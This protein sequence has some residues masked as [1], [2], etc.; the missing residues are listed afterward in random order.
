MQQAGVQYA[1]PAGAVEVQPG[2]EWTVDFG[3][4]TNAKRQKCGTSAS[5]D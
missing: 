4:L 1:F 5:A 2:K 3:G